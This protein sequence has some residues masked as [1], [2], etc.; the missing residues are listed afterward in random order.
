MIFDTNGISRKGKL[1]NQCTPVDI[2]NISD[3]QITTSR[4]GIYQTKSSKK[5]KK[6]SLEQEIRQRSDDPL[7]NN[8]MITVDET[9]IQ[10]HLLQPSTFDIATDGSY[11]KNN[12]IASYGWA[13]AM[14]TTVIAKAQGPVAAHPN[15]STPFRAEVYGIASALEF[16]RLMFDHYNDDCFRHKW[17]FLLDNKN[18]IQQMEWITSTPQTAK[19][20]LNPEVDILGLAAERMSAIPANYV[21]VKSHQD[22]KPKSGRLSYDAQLNCLADEL[23]KQQNDKML[24]PYTKHYP[25]CPQL[26]INNMTV[27]RESKTWIKDTA[28]K[29]PIQQY[30]HDKFKWTSVI[31]ES[32]HWTAQQTELKRY[33]ANDQRR[34]LKFVHG[35]LPTYDR[36]YPKAHLCPFN[37]LTL[38]NRVSI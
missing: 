37:D 26:K 27:T 38:E 11:N 19:W 7:F 5:I 1:L 29:I 10:Q 30:Y 34:I 22:R 9:D 12:G 24:H 23:A 35:W 8:I 32:I 3:T 16:I 25:N 6:T 20:H 31:F 36:L 15:L 17:F 4:A 28:G 21:H 18:L 33:E 13:I 2:I 14:N